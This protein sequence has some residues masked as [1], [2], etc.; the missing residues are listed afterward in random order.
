MAWSGGKLTTNKEEATLKFLKKKLERGESLSEEQ[1][2][3]IA[4]FT[5][6]ANAAESDIVKQV[7]LPGLH[8]LLP[9]Y[10]KAACL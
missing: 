2:A 10:M 5:L 4:R 1:A 7:S 8:R 9:R 3:V 6:A